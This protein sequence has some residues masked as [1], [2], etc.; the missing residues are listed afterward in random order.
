[1]AASY[2]DKLISCRQPNW[3]FLFTFALLVI[4]AF[5]AALAQ[6][7]A[8]ET[9]GTRLRIEITGGD[10]S[11]PVDMASIYVRFVVHKQMGKDEKPELDVKTNKEG[12]AVVPLVPRGK[13]TVQ[14]VADGWKPYG[15]SYVMTQEEQTI[16]IH[17]ERP[18]KWY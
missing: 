12:V 3:R 17:L 8:E 11:M 5:P 2:R 6:T 4:S 1:M 9:A 7:K 18:P 10:K 14:V 16:K 13:V 15:E